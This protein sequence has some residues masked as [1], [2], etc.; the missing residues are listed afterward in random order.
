MRRVHVACEGL[1]E[2]TFVREVLQPAL[3]GLHMIAY[4]PG[5]RVS[6][7][8][9]GR[10]GDIRYGRVWKD[11]TFTL[12]DDPACFCTTL[13]DYYALGTDFPSL[14]EPVGPDPEMRAQRIE[15]AVDKDIAEKMGRGF[16]PARFKCFLAMHEFEGLLFSAPTGLALGLGRGDLQGALQAIRDDFPT[17][18]HIDDGQDT[19][20]SKRL[21]AVWSGYD[22]VTGGNVAALEVGLDA[23]KHECSHFRSWFE[24]LESLGSMP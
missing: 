3:P 22:K 19:A 13:L 18:E 10:G 6:A 17:P 9:G 7:R 20:P 2:L 1:T 15:R 8:G 16:N 12:K 23:M 24:W 14:G 4:L 5:K 21:K 11:F